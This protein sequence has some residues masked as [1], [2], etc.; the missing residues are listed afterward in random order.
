[1]NLIDYLK[2]K[3]VNLSKKRLGPKK[4]GGYVIPELVLEK[5]SSLFNYGVE[6]EMNYEIEFAETYNKP[7]FMFD[8]TITPINPTTINQNLNYKH[9]GLGFTE[10]CSDFINHSDEYGFKENVLLKIDIESNEYSYFENVNMD[11]IAKRCIG[12]IIEAHY[13]SDIRWRER[14]F[15]MMDKI[16]EHFI[17]CHTHGNNFGSTFNYDGIYVMDVVELSF[18]RKD[19]V[20]QIINDTEKYPINNLDYPNNPSRHEIN[21]DFL[22]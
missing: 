2:P 21:L 22:S 9:E 18:I 8:H 19:L 12:I 10:N 1:M 5:C 17:L 7:V 11:E 13:I 15:K 6:N 4:D 16:N 20:E 3:N 14:F